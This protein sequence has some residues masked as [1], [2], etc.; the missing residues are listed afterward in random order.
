METVGTLLLV[1]ALPLV[2]VGVASMVAM[3]SALRARGEAV[4]WVFLRL[5]LPRYIARYRAATI[6]ETGRAGPL[7]RVFVISMNLAL[8]L[9]VLG[10][11]LR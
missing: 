10:L 8:V 1:L 2:V 11:L 5:F 6:R 4:D 7:F 9:V 3:A